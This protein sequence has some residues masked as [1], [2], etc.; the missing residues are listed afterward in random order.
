M[1]PLTGFLEI[2]F[3]LLARANLATGI[4]FVVD[5]HFEFEFEI[6]ILFLTEQEGVGTAFNGFALN[7]T[8][9]DRV[10]S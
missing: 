7:G 8:I 3:S 6:A 9:D 5:L 1:P 4:Q 2:L 10:V